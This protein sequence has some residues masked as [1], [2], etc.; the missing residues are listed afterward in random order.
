MHGAAVRRFDLEVD[1]AHHVATLSRTHDGEQVLALAGR[2]WPFAASP[3]GGTLHDVTLD[4][5][6]WPLTV[7]AVGE[8]ISVFAPEGAATLHEIDPIAHAADGAGEAGRLTAPM[9]G[10]V[11]ALLAR[12]GES[13]KKGQ[14][15][16]V[17]EAMKMEHTINAP[18]DGTVTELLYAVGDQVLEG[19]ELLRLD[20]AA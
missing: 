13:V 20:A 7:Y 1:G 16:A 19:E 17:M 5:R 11:I 3:R 15:L 10:K 4:R 14:A 8:R 12:C 6:R 18:C 9:P 2:Q